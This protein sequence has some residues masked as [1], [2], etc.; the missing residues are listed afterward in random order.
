MS[1]YHLSLFVFVKQ[2]EN[3]FKTKAG[4]SIQIFP[5]VSKKRQVYNL[6]Q[7]LWKGFII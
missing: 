3:I 1:Q 5:K 6:F 2:V 7:N 4:L